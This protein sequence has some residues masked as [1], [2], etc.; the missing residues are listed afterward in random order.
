MKTI[1][2]VDNQE[3]SYGYMNG[4]LEDVKSYVPKYFN[5]IYKSFIYDIQKVIDNYSIIYNNYQN[6]RK[7]KQNK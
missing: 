4:L 1:L 3:N 2:L 6:K 7:T 5:G